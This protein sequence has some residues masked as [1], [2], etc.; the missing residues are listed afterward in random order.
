MDGIT[1]SPILNIISTAS[2]NIVTAI[3]KNYPAIIYGNERVISVEDFSD[4]FLCSEED[5]LVESLEEE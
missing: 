3:P 5:D 1:C 2:I 4:F